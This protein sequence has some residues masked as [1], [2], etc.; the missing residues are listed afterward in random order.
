MDL[1]ILPCHSI[2]KGTGTGSSPDDWY[3]ASFQT[4]GN[5]HLYFKEHIQR[6]LECLKQN[7]HGSLIISGGA[8]KKEAGEVTEAESY[9]NL[10][11]SLN[12]DISP[13]IYLEPYA[14][15]SLENVIFLICRFYEVH[16]KYPRSIAIIGFEFKRTRFMKYHLP[17]LGLFVAE[18]IGNNP[19]PS[20]N[21]EDYYAE[22][23][24]NEHNHAVRH[25]A[26]DPYGRSMPLLGKK[27]DRNPFRRFHKYG[28]T[29]PRLSEF[30]KEIERLDKTDVELRNM[31]GA[32]P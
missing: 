15:D 9:Y 5:D 2:W 19:E 23:S 30:L 14:T 21:Q 31:L 25:F 24:A 1:I 29:N 32:L 3:L 16:H 13:R 4:E 11:K 28:E 17:A 18:Y 22:L 12:K 27:R 26:I 6:S 20:T 10:A 7:P 8:T